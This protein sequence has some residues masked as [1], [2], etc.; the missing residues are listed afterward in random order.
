MR[1][2]TIKAPS[3]LTRSQPK[4]IIVWLRPT[5]EVAK[6]L[7][8]QPKCSSMRRFRAN[9]P[10]IK[11]ARRAKFLMRAYRVKR[12]PARHLETLPTVQ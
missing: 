1:F 12:D 2:G 11:N 8:R 9:P 7:R 10:R 5:V 3:M 4:R 6:P